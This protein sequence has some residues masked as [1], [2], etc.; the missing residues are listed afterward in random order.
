MEDKFGIGLWHC[1]PGSLGH[2]PRQRVP[3][4][5]GIEAERLAQVGNRQED[6]V[7]LRNSGSLISSPHG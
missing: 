4:G 5:I 7:D 2:S 6:A 1:Q 3:E